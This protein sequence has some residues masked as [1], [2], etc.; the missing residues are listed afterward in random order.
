MSLK[1]LYGRDLTNVI[2]NSNDFAF[3]ATVSRGV[4]TITPN[5]IVSMQEVKTTDRGG[6][7]ISRNY[8]T[9]LFPVSQYD[10]T[11]GL[12]EPSIMD[13]YTIESVNYEPTTPEGMKDCWE[14]SDG[15]SQIYKVF[16]E[17]VA[18]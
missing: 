5:V 6:F 18:A 8:V 1:G 10:F 9:L 14:Y 12:D 7:E 11:T 4:Q 15:T 17:E 16:V 13:R 2:F 3:T